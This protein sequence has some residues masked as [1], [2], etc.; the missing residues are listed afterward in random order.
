[1]RIM[2]FYQ[3]SL[4]YQIKARLFDIDNVVLDT[5]KESI[6]ISEISLIMFAGSRIRHSKQKQICCLKSKVQT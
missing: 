4:S 3:I 6:T 1:M 2:L 5:Q